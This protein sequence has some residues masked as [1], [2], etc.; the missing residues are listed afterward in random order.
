MTKIIVLHGIIN[1]FSSVDYLVGLVI[2]YRWCI[3]I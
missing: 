2:R 3:D 1:Y